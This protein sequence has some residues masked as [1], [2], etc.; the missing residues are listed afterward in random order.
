MK[1]TNF[2]LVNILLCLGLSL[3]MGCSEDGDDD[4]NNGGIPDPEGTV[5][6][7][8][9]NTNNSA[10]SG[11]VKVG[12]PITFGDSWF[13]M[14]ENNNFY[15]GYYY[16]KYT[17]CTIANVGK[18]SSLGSI[19]KIPTSGYVEETSVEIGYGYVIRANNA[20][21]A[22]LYVVDWVLSTGGGI[23]GAKVKYQYPFIP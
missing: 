17:G 20:T 13:C 12:P 19:T 16:S 14:N 18:V 21:Y 23:L 22:R 6:I 5:M 4:G 1:K 8:M 10:A 15:G 2:L 9:A 3:V 11:G 7:S